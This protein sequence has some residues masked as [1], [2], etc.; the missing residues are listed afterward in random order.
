MNDEVLQLSNA[1]H[2]NCTMQ[3]IAKFH[4]EEYRNNLAKI[5]YKINVVTAKYKT[6]VIAMPFVFLCF[7]L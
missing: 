6:E 5:S 7:K 4:H 3:S 2:S 1:I